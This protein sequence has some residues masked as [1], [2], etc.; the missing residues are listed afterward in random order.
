M[1]IAFSRYHSLSDREDVLRLTKSMPKTSPNRSQNQLLARLSARDFGL[2]EPHLESVDLPLRRYLEHRNREIE[3]VYFLETGIA[4]VVANAQTARSIEVGLIGREGVTGCA[5]IT[6]GGRSPH[7]TFMQV[8]G[9]GLRMEVAPFR[10]AIAQSA[11]LRDVLLKHLHCY[12]VQTAQTAF[13]NGR[14]KIEE[15]LARW[16]LMA[17]DRLD[18]EEAPLTH[19]FLAMM[20]GVRRPGVTMALKLL[21]QRGL[22]DTQRGVIVILDRRGLEEHAGAFY[23]VPEGE[24]RRMF[25]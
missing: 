3:D 21:E 8:A 10:E 24:W 20:L 13:A 23:G 14:G 6:G 1:N 11:T 2:I 25:P 9:S 7:D 22:I 18:G 16:L 19:E 12:I 5:I 17:N 15:R 4:S